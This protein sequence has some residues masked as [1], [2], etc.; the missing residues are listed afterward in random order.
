M[1]KLNI[2]QSLLTLIL[3][4]IALADVPTTEIHPDLI[5]TDQS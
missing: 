2:A 1:L 3:I 5:G 4:Q